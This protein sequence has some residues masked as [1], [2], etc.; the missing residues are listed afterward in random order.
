MGKLVYFCEPD[1]D[2]DAVVTECPD[3]GSDATYDDDGINCSNK[4]CPN[5]KS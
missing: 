2:D 5:S 1:D 3:C 4:D